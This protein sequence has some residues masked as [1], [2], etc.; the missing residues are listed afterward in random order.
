MCRDDQQAMKVLETAYSVKFLEE[1]HTDHQTLFLQAK[2]DAMRIR[3]KCLGTRESQRSSPSETSS[4]RT[5]RS[6]AISTSSQWETASDRTLQGASTSSRREEEESP[7]F[8]QSIPTDPPTPPRG[9]FF[10]LKGW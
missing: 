6:Q 5:P 1:K 8:Y 9:G 3:E 2:S 10:G 7:R 4:Y